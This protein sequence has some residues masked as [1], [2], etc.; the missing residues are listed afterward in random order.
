[1][2]IKSLGNVVI[3][4]GV[5][6]V[7]ASLFADNIGIGG[8][9]GFGLAQIFGLIVGP[10]VSFLGFKLRGQSDENVAGL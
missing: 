8:S 9:S 7:L 3:I 10:F 6:I 1:M 2:H 5:L 4:V